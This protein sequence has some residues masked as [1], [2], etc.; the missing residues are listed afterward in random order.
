MK[1][2][3]SKFVNFC[4]FKKIKL[5]R[6]LLKKQN[7]GKKLGYHHL[8]K[9][10]KWLVEKGVLFFISFKISQEN[11]NSKSFKTNVPILEMVCKNICA[12]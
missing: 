4:H 2:V 3:K 6:W 7:V 9:H 10:Q 5:T 1:N 8:I 12:E 11:I